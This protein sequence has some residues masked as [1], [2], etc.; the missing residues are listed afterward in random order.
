MPYTL[1]DEEQEDSYYDESRLKGNPW[2]RR[3]FHA[4]HRT[5]TKKILGIS[6]YAYRCLFCT[7]I[8]YYGVKLFG[9]CWYFNYRPNP[10]FDVDLL[11]PLYPKVDKITQ[12]YIAGTRRPTGNVYIYATNKAGVQ[13]KLSVPASAD[14]AEW[15]K[16]AKSVNNFVGITDGQQSD[17]SDAGKVFVSAI[18]DQPLA[19]KESS[20]EEPVS[21]WEQ[22]AISGKHAT[23]SDTLRAAMA[24]E[25]IILDDDMPPMNMTPSPDKPKPEDK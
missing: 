8:H 3:T 24:E 2:A 14:P 4:W 13:G 16:L 17:E 15:A 21:Q 20:E 19:E 7:N 11:G 12:E 1:E 6:F 22:D 25:G 23:I 9:L 18:T 10:K 5:I